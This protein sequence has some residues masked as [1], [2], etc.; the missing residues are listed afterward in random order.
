[1]LCQAFCKNCKK[2]GWRVGF[3]KRQAA[4]PDCG[5][6]L[7]CPNQAVK[8]YTLCQTH[9]GPAPH[10]GWYG[11]GK[12]VNGSGSQ[13]PITRL[14]AKYN[15][16]QKDGR[17]LSNRAAVEIIDAR[18]LQLAERIDVDDAPDRL[19][20]LYNLWQEYTEAKANSRKVDEIAKERQLDAAFEKARTDYEAWNQMMTALDLRRRMIESEV[21]VLKEIKAIMTAEDA[22]ELTAK[23]LAAVMRVV[24]DPTKLKQVQY[25]FTRIIGEPGDRSLKASVSNAGRSSGEEDIE[26]GPGEMDRE[27]LLHPGDQ[28]RSEAEG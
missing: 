1:M 3:G 4:C 24:D 9:G 25:E 20:L 18:V 27:E 15:Q 7:H 12:L 19:N 5:N 28:E 10:R 23:L 13:F 16:S 14:A 2:C 26:S 6:D 8:G 22:Y 11:K 17:L 21:K